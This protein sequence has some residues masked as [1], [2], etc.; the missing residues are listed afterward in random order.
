[1]VRAVLVV[2]VVSIQPL[3]G[4]LC[5]RKGL[6]QMT[7]VVEGTTWHPDTTSGSQNSFVGPDTLFTFFGIS[8]SI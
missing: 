2:T 1:M 5:D 4:L 7:F 6:D 8:A 3:R